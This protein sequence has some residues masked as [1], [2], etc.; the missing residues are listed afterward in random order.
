MNRILDSFLLFTFVSLF[1]DE[2]FYMIKHLLFSVFIS[3]FIFTAGAQI[4]VSPINP[5]SNETVEIVFDA[6]KGNKALFGETDDVYFHAGL[7]TATSRDDKDW[8]FVRGNWGVADAE[9]LMEPLG[10]DKYRMS[11]IPQEFFHLDSDVE[12]RQIALVFRN[13]NGEKVAKT[14]NETDFLIPLNG[15]KPPKEVQEEYVIE[16]QKFLSYSISNNQLSIHTQNGAIRFQ[17]FTKDILKV[18]FIPKNTA[19]LDTSISVVLKPQEIQAVIS[20][21]E[22]K[23]TWSTEAFNLE[24]QKDPFNI[25]YYYNNELL[26]KEERGFFQRTESCGLRFCLDADEAIYGTGE[27]AV[28]LNRRGY[29]LDLYNRPDYNYAK[30][31]RNLNYTMPV[32]LSDK[33]YLLFI[34]NNQKA[35]FDIGETEENILE[36][37]AIG[38]EMKYY[39]VAGESFAEISQS[40]TELVGR[41]PLPPRWALGNLQSRMAYRTQAEVES[42]VDEMIE[43]DFPLDAVILDFYWF[44][45]SILGHLGNLDWYAKNWPQPEKMIKNFKDKGVKTI[46]IT[47]PFV[48]DTSYWFVHGDTSALFTTNKQGETYVMKEF[49]FGH[50]ALMD[51]FK[52]Q[53]KDWFWEQYQKQIE[54]G[55]AGWWGDLGEPETHPTDMYHVNGKADEVHNM[56]AHEWAAMVFRKYQEHYP[57]QRLFHLNRS[58]AVG[59]Q[60]YSIF[61][62][63]GDVSRSWSGFQAQL[64]LMLN[65]SLCGLGYI[66][67]DLGGFALGKKDEELYT[68][69]LQMGVFNPVFRPHGSG[70]PSEPIFFSESTQDIVRESIKLRYRLMPYIYSAAYENTVTGKP[71]VK[72]LFF[73]HDNVKF[74]D[75]SDAY[76]FGDELIAV[77]VTES[78][79]KIKNVLLPDGGWYDF[80]TDQYYPRGAMLSLDVDMDHIPVFV[81]GGA[82]IPMLQDYTTTDQY[83][84]SELFIHYYPGTEGEETT[85]TLFEDDGKNAKNLENRNYQ[86][87]DFKALNNDKEIVISL[88]RNRMKYQKNQKNRRIIFVLHNIAEMPQALELD[89]KKIEIASP[90]DKRRESAIKANY[91]KDKML[92]HIDMLWEYDQIELKVKR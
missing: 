37:S 53:T 86:L 50:A 74:K 25:S 15:Y 7:I 11:F 34:D 5:K 39:I 77:P 65:M 61:P 24:I 23:V 3:F 87:I 16:S 82:F 31:A 66:S 85:Y 22:K 18:F 60:R 21:D 20:E 91:D 84:E 6:G 81:K 40:F 52:P 76:Y 9:F 51:M 42:I 62:W 44:G 45:D 38:G 58:G 29:K 2:L 43:K 49:Y 88:D 69:W 75:Y 30:N 67:S 73:Y 35:Y 70:I 59:T 83:P 14:E 57:Q 47:E 17:Y 56:Y 78:G 1:N 71:I 64:P 55:I 46:L 80:F 19:I 41:Q 4:T 90:L 36:F 26:L 12:V 68:R 13:A 33:K 92:L 89:G 72:P 28:P 10:G 79:Q 63:S 27:R 32:L 8:K 54:I 48:I